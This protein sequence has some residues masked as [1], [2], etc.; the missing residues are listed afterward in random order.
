M[1][2]A[3]ALARLF[4]ARLFIVLWLL[5]LATSAPSR[6][7]ESEPAGAK[8][9]EW[10]NLIDSAGPV[11]LA[12]LTDRLVLCGDVRAEGGSRRLLAS[13]GE[14]VVAVL[15]G[16]ASKNAPDL[17][18]KQSF[19]DCVVEAEFLIG[20]NSNAGVKLQEKYEVQIYDSH[21]KAKPTGRDCGGVYPRWVPAIGG[22]RY[23]SKGSP[24]L[25]NAA[26]P[27]GEWQTLRI[28]FRAPRFDAEGKKTENARFVSVELNGQ[29]V[30][31]DFELTAPTGNAKQPLP[32]AA[33]A[34]LLLQVN[35][36]PVAFRNVRILPTTL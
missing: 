14:G 29:K 15:T 16:S 21:G 35:H 11:G 12:A 9:P 18:S 24:P 28:E 13:P 4:P 25:V 30:Q 8:P 7:E 26:K 6:A 10:V 2:P 27:A 33:A 20:K 36:G 22:L 32:E 31:R 3:P 1:L 23:I 34:P 5:P 17:L 19:G